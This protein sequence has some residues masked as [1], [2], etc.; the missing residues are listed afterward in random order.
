[1]GRSSLIEARVLVT[2]GVAFALSLFPLLAGSVDAS[3]G[4]SVSPASSSP[5]MV[6][7]NKLDALTSA[8]WGSNLNFDSGTFAN[9]TIASDMN[10]TPVVSI[11]LSLLNTATLNDAAMN[12]SAD[13]CAWLHCHPEITVS[14]PDAYNYSQFVSYV[15]QVSGDSHYNAIVANA[16]WVYGNEPYLWTNAY[17]SVGANY[18]LIVQNFTKAVRATYPSAVVTAYEGSAKPSF[19]AQYVANATKDEGT[20]LDYVNFQPYNGGENTTDTPANML[21]AMTTSPNSIPIGVPYLRSLIYASCNACGKSFPLQ[22]GEGGPGSAANYPTSKVSGWGATAYAF[23]GLQAMQY[24]VSIFRFWTMV[25]GSGSNGCE[26]GAIHLAGQCN[27]T[28]NPSYYDWELE[29]K[30]GTGHAWNVTF[31]GSPSIY[32][33]LINDTSTENQLFIVDTNTSGGSATVTVPNSMWPGTPDSVTAHQITPS[34][35]TSE[36]STT[37]NPVT[38]PTGSVTVL[39]VVASTQSGGGGGSSGGG[40]GSTGGGGGGTSTNDSPTGGGSPGFQL[41]FPSFSLT[42]PP[43]GAS[44]IVGGILIAMGAIMVLFAPAY[45]KM[46]GALMAVVGVVLLVI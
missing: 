36:S 33:V 11:R 32:G 25:G 43:L 10:S 35:Y 4:S 5:A 8:F 26:V 28:Y 7:G 18:G 46:A 27:T 39:D 3:A 12:E 16:T 20:G 13:F 14:G 23:L 30:L 24:N 22:I 34:V 17:S 6:L 40:G 38:L 45:G 15:G 21:A 44:A 42:L 41:H 31:P 9:S 1:M 2:I 19:A 29:Q 37:A